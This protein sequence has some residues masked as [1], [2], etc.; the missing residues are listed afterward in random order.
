MGL[1]MTIDV[2]IPCGDS[3]STRTIA[4]L[5]IGLIALKHNETEVIRPIHRAYLHKYLFYNAF[6]LTLI[7]PGF[8]IGHVFR[9]IDRANINKTERL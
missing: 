6:L 3:H 5:A 4:G 8:G 1:F 7:L 9:A 2:M